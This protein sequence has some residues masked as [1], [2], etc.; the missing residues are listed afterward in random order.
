MAAMVGKS[1]AG[2]C[3]STALLA[4]LLLFVPFHFRFAIENVAGLGGTSWVGGFCVKP[5]QPGDLVAREVR[6]GG[7]QVRQ[8]PAS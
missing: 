7:W 1:V 2:S 6:Q 3:Y 4:A 8:E 5:I